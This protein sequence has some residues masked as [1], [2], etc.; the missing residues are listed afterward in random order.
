[1]TPK[2]LRFLRTFIKQLK[3]RPWGLVLVVIY[4]VLTAA[5]M[6]ITTIFLLFALEN[7][8][9]VATFARSYIWNSKLAVV[10]WLLEKVTVLKPSTL[11]FSAIAAGVYTIVTAIEAIGLWYEKTWGKFL[12]V[13]LVGVSLPIEVF[14]LFHGASLLKWTIFIA[15]LA[16]F[17]YLL[18]ELRHLGAIPSCH[19]AKN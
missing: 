12:V 15:N 6:T 16:V 7:H 2:R 19:S 11:L 14:E 13:G 10:G 4:K 9:W 18:R 3:S 5:L 8:Q 1:M 17:S